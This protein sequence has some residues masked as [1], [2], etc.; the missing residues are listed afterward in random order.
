MQYIVLAHD[1]T[2]PEAKERRQRVREKHLEGIRPAVE[3]GVLQLGGA[4]LDAEGGMIGSALIVEADD[5][6]AVRTFLEGDIYRRSGVW[7]RFEIYPFR[8]AV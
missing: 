6:A 4:I 2:D 7:Q 8:R 5:E 3:S 1:G